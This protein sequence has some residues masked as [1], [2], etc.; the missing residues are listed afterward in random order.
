M[1]LM[2]VEVI[3]GVQKEKQNLIF[4]NFKVA[5]LA[6]ASRRTIWLAAGFQ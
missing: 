2:L 3:V 1:D 5:G 4:L 6:H